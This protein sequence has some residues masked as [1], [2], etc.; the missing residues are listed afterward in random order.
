MLLKIHTA[1]K[2]ILNLPRSVKQ[3]IVVIVDLS[4]CVLSTWFAFYL[5]LDQFILIQGVAL[6]AAMVSVALALPV[7][8]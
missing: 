2:D 3:I 7:F 6:T 8:W 1:T 4:L 5:R